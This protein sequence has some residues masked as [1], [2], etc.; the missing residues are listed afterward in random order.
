MTSEN[1]NQSGTGDRP[2]AA[3]TDEIDAVDPEQVAALDDESV[4]D[5]GPDPEQFEDFVRGVD[6]ERTASADRPES[7]VPIDASMDELFGEQ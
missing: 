7:S 4:A 5:D 1:G 2:F 6:P 3:S